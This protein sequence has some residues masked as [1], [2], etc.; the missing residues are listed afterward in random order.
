MAP[1]CTVRMAAV[2]NLAPWPSSG[3]AVATQLGSSR[4]SVTGKRTWLAAI[5]TPGLLK[6]AQHTAG[7]LREKNVQPV[8]HS[9][10]GVDPTRANQTPDREG[11]RTC[12]H[13]HTRYFFG[14]SG[15][16]ADIIAFLG[17]SSTCPC[18]HSPRL[19]GLTLI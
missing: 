15:S 2:K 14:S 16:R 13:A 19:T 7:I 1:H 3:F 18:C 10:S 12:Q 9:S 4:M 11:W 17:L 6:Q 5:A 8:P